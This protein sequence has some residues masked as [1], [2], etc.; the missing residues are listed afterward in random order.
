MK[1]TIWT[2]QHTGDRYILI[3]SFLIMTLLQINS[4]REDTNSKFWQI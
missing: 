3:L 2:I 4:C 1:V